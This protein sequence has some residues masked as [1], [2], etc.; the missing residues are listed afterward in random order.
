V[1]K[2]SISTISLNHTLVEGSGPPMCPPLRSFD[3]E[4]VTTAQVSV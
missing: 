2:Y 1:C 3:K 4:D